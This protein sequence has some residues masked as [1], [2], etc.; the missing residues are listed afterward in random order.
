MSNIKL[1]LVDNKINLK[2]KE[3]NI[4][5]IKKFIPK[6]TTST[7]QIVKPKFSNKPVINL[8]VIDTDLTDVERA[9]NE[10]MNTLVTP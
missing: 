9:E 4:I 6:R 5:N 1:T 10:G 7:D 2:D 3:I 8:S